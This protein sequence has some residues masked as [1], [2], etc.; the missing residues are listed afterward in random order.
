LK[1]NILIFFF[2]KKINRRTRR[3]ATYYIFYIKHL[4]YISNCVFFLI[5]AFHSKP[6]SFNIPDDS[7]YLLQIFLNY[8]IIV[9]LLTILFFLVDDF[10]NKYNENNSN[11]SKAI[12]TF[13][14]K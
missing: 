12:P 5:K 4:I 9:I 8:Y 6:Y 10:N 11:I 1:F 13:K 7:K 3:Y 14:S 2:K